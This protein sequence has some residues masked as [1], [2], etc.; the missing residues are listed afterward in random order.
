MKQFLLFLTIALSLGAVAMANIIPTSTTI[1]GTGPFTWTYDLQLSKDQN[2]NSGTAPTLNPVPHTNLTFGGFLTIYDFAGYLP[3]T[4]AGPAGW[5]CSAQNVGFTP[6]DVVP[7][8]NPGVVDITWAYTT[9]STILGQPA[10]QDLGMFSAQSI[11]STATQVSYASRGIA[12]SGPQVG[13]IADN[14]GNTQG[15]SAVPEP[16]SV[17]S[18]GLGLVLL[19]VVRRKAKSA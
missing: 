19:G 4:C 16:A 3:G 18:I 14:V 1:T 6:D 15:P 5:T 9:G 17:L 11:F 8:D 10:G 12:N 13:T 2:V 7:T